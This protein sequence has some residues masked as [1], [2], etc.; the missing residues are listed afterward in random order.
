MERKC[1]ENQMGHA[2]EELPER[3]FCWGETLHRAEGHQ[4]RSLKKKIR[5]AS[6][7]KLQKASWLKS[8]RTVNRRKRG[9]RWMSW[10]SRGDL[11]ESRESSCREPSSCW[12]IITT[13]IHT[14]ILVSLWMNKGAKWTSKTQQVQKKERK[15][16]TNS[17]CWIL[18][19]LGVCPGDLWYLGNTLH[20][21]K[22]KV[23]KRSRGES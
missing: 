21:S 10:E 13:I 18:V 5:A 1:V 4:G 2:G 3:T 11:G 20:D 6:K 12:K 15:N 9:A 7:E 16:T 17:S 23:V 22:N 19:L 8:R 14:L